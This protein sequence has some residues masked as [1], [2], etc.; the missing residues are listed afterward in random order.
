MASLTFN[1]RKCWKNRADCVL[2]AMS[3]RS[4]FALIMTKQPVK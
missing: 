2:F 1:I 3:L 4:E